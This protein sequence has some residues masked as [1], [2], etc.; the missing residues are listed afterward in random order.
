MEFSDH[1]KLDVEKIITSFNNLGIL[2]GSCGKTEKISLSILSVCLIFFDNLFD[3]YY[4]SF[5]YTDIKALYG[6]LSGY[7][8]SRSS[9]EGSCYITALCET[10][11]AHA[12]D[13]N[14]DDLMKLTDKKLRDLSY[15]WN[16]IQVSSIEDRGFNQTLFFNPGY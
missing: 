4:N 11:P 13:V 1:E 10:W 2:S 16:A 14:I 15:E 5:I 8:A 12:H 3:F 6:T 9:I 7:L